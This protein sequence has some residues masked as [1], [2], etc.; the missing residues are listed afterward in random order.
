LLAHW[1]FRLG[2]SRFINMM[3]AVNYDQIPRDRHHSDRGAVAL[4]GGRGLVLDEE[5]DL[6]GLDLLAFIEESGEGAS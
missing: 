6:A 5:G 3:E 1:P 4:A 2:W